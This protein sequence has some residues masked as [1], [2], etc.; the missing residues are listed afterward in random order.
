[1]RG[2]L[3]TTTTAAATT[4]IQADATWYGKNRGTHQ[5]NDGLIIGSIAGRAELA[6]KKKE[7]RCYDTT[8]C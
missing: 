5:A 4:T 3:T 6:L 2:R 8:Y 1:Q 7:D